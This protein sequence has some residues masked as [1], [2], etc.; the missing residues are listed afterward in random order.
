M[1]EFIAA[2]GAN[3]EIWKMHPDELREQDVNARV[4]PPEMLERLAETIRKEKRLESLPLACKRKNHFELMSGHHRLRA[5]RM[6]QLH[7][8]FVLVD[9]R[10][11]RR[12][13]VVAKQIAHNRISG[14]DDQATLASLFQE[15]TRVDDILESYVSAADF[16]TLE[17]ADSISIPPLSA[18]LP[19]YLVNFAFLPAA[20]EKFELL[21]AQI[22]KLPKDT[23]LI[24]VASADIYPRFAEAVGVVTKAENVR[25]V[26]AIITRMLDITLAHF[27]SL[28]KKHEG[29]Q[30]APDTP[31][32]HHG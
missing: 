14:M 22:K 31:E 6:A 32:A 13:Q 10:D 11:L 21:E 17:S 29:P 23:D 25:S 16:G 8:I 15:I 20:V 28:E 27:A 18:I 19:W 5:A 24:G 2:A 1:A 7:E 30:A 12:S 26:G 3:L 9:T 4:M